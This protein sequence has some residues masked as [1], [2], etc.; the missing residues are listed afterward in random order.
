MK[1]KVLALIFLFNYFCVYSQQVTFRNAAISGPVFTFKAVANTL[2]IGSGSALEIFDITDI[3]NIQLIG[4]QHSTDVVTYIA[5]KGNTVY[6]GNNGIGT[7]IFDINTP[8]QP[9]FKGLIYDS[10]IP[11]HQPPVIDGNTGFFSYGSY[12][13]KVLDL[14]NA[15]QPTEICDW[16]TPDFMLSIGKMGDTIFA[17]DRTY[18]LFLLDF[19]NNQLSVF[20]TITTS[21]IQSWHTFH[22]DTAHNYLWLY[23]Y[24]SAVPYN[25][26]LAVVVYNL[27]PLSFMDVVSEFKMASR[28]AASLTTKNN[29]AYLSCWEDGVRVIDF[30]N[31]GTPQQTAI[32]PSASYALWVD[33]INDSVLGIAQYDSG[34]ELFNINNITP[35]LLNTVDTYGDISSIAMSGNYVYSIVSGEGI[36]V[37]KIETSDSLKEISLLRQYPNVKDLVVKNNTLLAASDAHG[38]LVFD[39]TDKEFPVLT[40]SLKKPSN[41]GA[42]SLHLS[43]NTLF[44]GESYHFFLSRP[45]L[46]SVWDIS[47]INN[48]VFRS[49]T[50]ITTQNFPYDRP[51]IFMDVQDSQMVMSCWNDALEGSLHILDVQNTAQ[52][53]ILTEMPARAGQL[54]M[55]LINQQPA[56]LCAWGTSLLSQF[57][58]LRI[59][60]LNNPLAPVLIGEYPTGMNGNRTIGLAVSDH[61]VYLSE[62]GLSAHGFITVLDYSKP[63]LPQLHSRLKIGSNTNHSHLKVYD[64]Y[65]LHSAGSPGLMLFKISGTTHIPEYS[66]QNTLGVCVYPNPFNDFVTIAFDNTEN[67]N[68]TLEIFNAQGAL[69]RTINNIRNNNTVVYKNELSK[70]LYMFRLKTARKEDLVGTFVAE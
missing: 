5:T 15:Q 30:S 11:G 64:N 51:M 20:D 54:K 59:F 14:N 35:A 53:S 19:S 10:L 63:T 40:D 42:L 17:A 4:K 31:M 27:D 22:I 8:S 41:N 23:G 21:A 6:A 61:Y 3:N 52:I 70:G 67:D 7:A 18:G 65:L 44:V 38:V 55:K 43:G 46:L 28:P 26:S 66:T 33:F 37:C 29:K 49:E 62:G 9:V 16:Q 58:G 45:V 69:V 2:Y 24:G 60:A 25:D 48:P 39:I 56:V 68:Y 36:A 34:L 1:I 12:G 50:T 13:I 32:I 47:N 57:N